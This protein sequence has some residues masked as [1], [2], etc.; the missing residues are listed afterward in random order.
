MWLSKEESS[1]V[2]LSEEGGGMIKLIVKERYEDER[3]RVEEIP[4]LGSAVTGVVALA[5]CDPR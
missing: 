1:A 2:G 5:T 4:V 3:G